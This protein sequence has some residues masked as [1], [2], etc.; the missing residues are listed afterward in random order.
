MLCG[1]AGRRGGEAADVFEVVFRQLADGLVQLQQPCHGAAAEDIPRAGGV[2]GMHLGAD[3]AESRRPRFQQAAVRP[4]RHHGEGHAEL[5][6]QLV[7]ALL[8]GAVPEEF[9][10]V[11]AD[12]HHVRLTQTPE[13]LLLRRVR[14]RPQGKPQIGVAADELPLRFGV[15]HCL[16]GRRADRFVRQAQGAEVEHLG[17]VNEGLVHFLPPQ[18]GIR[19]GLP[20]EGEGAVA[21]FI[22]GHKGQRG[23]HAVVHQNAFRLNS[24]G[25]QRPQQQIAESVVSHLAQ[26]RGLSAV[27]V[28]RGQKIAGGAAGVG[29]HGGVSGAVRGLCR[30]INEQFAQRYYVDHRAHPLSPWPRGTRCRADG[31]A[32]RPPRWPGS[33]PWAG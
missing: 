11:V 16:L 21:A 13:H 5:R 2:H 12:F 24:G 20:G 22:E 29:G 10:L 32:L 7:R 23:K 28:Q 4:Q 6:Q 17:L 3:G 9:H 25:V 31:K 1:Q 14:I 27:G 30:K 18:L 15:G 26:K 19:A 8:R 33:G